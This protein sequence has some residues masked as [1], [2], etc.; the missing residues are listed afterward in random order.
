MRSNEE[1]ISGG[2][3]FPVWKFLPIFGRACVDFRL[4]LSFSSCCV[5]S[6]LS[7]SVSVSPF[8]AVKIRMQAK[9]RLGTYSNSIDCARKTLASE[10]VFGFYR[11]LETSL[12]RTGAWNGVYFATIF[13]LQKRE[14]FGKDA[15]FLPGF[16]GGVLG[17]CVNHPLDTASTRI[18]NLLPPEPHRYP[19]GVLKE[20]WIKEGPR[21]LY[22]GFLPKVLRLGPG[23]GLMILVFERISTYLEQRRQ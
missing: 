6:S 17:V 9:N 3:F 2:F 7:N 22:R 21:A 19:I 18:R 11:G 10:G 13:E 23:G 5:D 4:F 16:C 14:T 1:S 8:E 12:V 15:H 20:I